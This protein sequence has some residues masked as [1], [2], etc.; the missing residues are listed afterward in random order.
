MSVAMWFGLLVRFNE[1]RRNFVPLIQ[2]AAIMIDLQK[3]IDYWITGAEEDLTTADL[4]LKMKRYLHGMFFCHL[5][6]EKVLK[7][8][9]VKSKMDVPPRTHNLIYLAGTTGIIFDENDPDFLG[10]LMKYQLEGRYPDYI[11][12][13]PQQSDIEK[14][15]K[16][17]K[18]LF[19]W[20]KQKL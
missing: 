17:T 5:S 4:L 9:Y 8:H 6:I 15:L 1:N 2:I 14:Y 10:I 18:E 11:P 13:V 16:R 12:M 7:A 3:Q 19:E 20:L